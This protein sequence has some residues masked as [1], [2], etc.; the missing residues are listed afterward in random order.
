[1]VKSW[2]VY[3]IIRVAL[4]FGVFAILMVANTPFWL[5]AIIAA[6]FNL[7]FSYLFLRGRRDELVTDLQ[8]RRAAGIDA[9]SDEAIEDA[10]EPRS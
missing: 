6:V 2:V 3:S 7:C 10:P 1:M 5:A 8:A 9:K 4:F